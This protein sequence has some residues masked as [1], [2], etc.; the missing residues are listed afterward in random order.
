MDVGSD[1]VG[2]DNG[3]AAQLGVFAHH[4]DSVGDDSLDGL[5]V[6]FGSLEGIQVS[7]LAGQRS[8]SDLLSVS[9]EL[10]VHG[11]EVG[12]A[13]ELDKRASL[14]V[15]GDERHDGAF[16]GGT[17]SLL[18]D[19]GKTAGAQDVDGLLQFAF[20]LHERL[21]ALH[22]A[23]AGHFTEFLHESGSNLSHVLP[24]SGRAA[25]PCA[26]RPF[27]HEVSFAVSVPTA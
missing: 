10:L 22:H 16:V 12:L 7:R 19:S 20:G 17:A 2:L 14:A 3:E 13:V 5:A 24:F 4:V 8:T 9:L 18:G 15:L 25:G 26:C 23:S 1:G 6:N 21:L 11:H 27:L